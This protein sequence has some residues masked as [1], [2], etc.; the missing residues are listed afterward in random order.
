MIRLQLGQDLPITILCKNATGV[1]SD[2]DVAPVLSIY[3]SSAKKLSGESM[4]VLE[5]AATTGLFKAVI[6]LDERFSEG[7]HTAVVRY[8]VSSHHGM[9][10][11]PFRILPGGSATGQV[12]SMFRFDLPH[13][14]YLINQRSS[15]RIYKGKNPRV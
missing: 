13:L 15:G 10:V 5:S 1:P 12:I 8:K 3:S 14:T 4:P 6:Y 9:E 2:P 7:K 11:I